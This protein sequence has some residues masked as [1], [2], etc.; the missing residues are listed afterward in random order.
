MTSDRQRLDLLLVARGLAESREKAR[1]LIL[2]GRVAVGGDTSLKPGSLVPPDA[3]LRVV[4]P[5]HP[6]VGRGGVKLAHALQA[7]GIRVAGRLAVDIGASTGGFTD[8]L[9]H[10]G[11][12]RV[13]AVD[14][15]RHQLHWKLRADSRVTLLEGVNARTL[16][17][18]DLPDLGEGADIVTIDVSFISLRL[19]LP[20]VPPLLAP[21]ADVIALVKPQFEAGRKDV[22]RRGLVQD[23]AVHAR[24]IAS[25]SEAAAAVGLT[26]VGLT[27]SPIAGAAGN[28]EFFLHLTPHGAEAA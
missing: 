24:V 22:G 21:G 17:R 19:I 20:V 7:F 25:V 14:V 10:A 2:A 23:P 26:R 3:D 16:A 11:A 13:I 9:L 28:R 6:W 12:R 8:V 18:V 4:A 15:G 1:A 5:E 27:E